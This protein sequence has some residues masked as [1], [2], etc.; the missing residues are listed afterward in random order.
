MDWWG[1]KDK[2]QRWEK[3]GKKWARREGN[4]RGG[5]SYPPRETLGK[6]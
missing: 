5:V 4:S 1:G 2:Q 6:N 3:S